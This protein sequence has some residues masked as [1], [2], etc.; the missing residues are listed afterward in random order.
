[1][2]RTCSTPHIAS[3]ALLCGR[4]RGRAVAFQQTVRSAVR[5][6]G[7]FLVRP[8]KTPE[9]QTGP[10]T[11]HCAANLS[12]QCKESRQ[13]HCRTTSNSPSVIASYAELSS[14][15]QQVLYV[16]TPSCF[17]SRAYCR[18]FISIAVFTQSRLRESELWTVA[19][20]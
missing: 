4:L 19:C 15:L 3:A 6:C 12:A 17:V 14:L 20:F 9:S 16:A 1:L 13:Q 5:S 18:R 7:L 11:I 2:L 10:I 8:L